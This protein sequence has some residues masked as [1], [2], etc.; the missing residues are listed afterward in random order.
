MDI[1]DD[2]GGG[3]GIIPGIEVTTNSSSSHD[4][5]LDLRDNDSSNVNE[6]DILVRQASLANTFSIEDLTGSGTTASN[7]ESFLVTQ[8]PGNTARVRTGGSVV[9]YTTMNL[10]N[11]NTPAP[12]T[13]LM[14]A[15]GGV[16][17][18]QPVSIAVLSQVELD[19]LVMEA[20]N[21]WAATGLSP[22]QIATL[23]SVKVEIADLPDAYLAEIAGGH[24]RIDQDAGG[25]GWF[26][27]TTPLDD[28]EFS[29]TTFG[30][31]RY[32]D[33]A[34]A[35]AGR[36]DLLTALMHELGHHLGLPDEYT[37]QSRDT[38]MHGYLTPGE[39][40]LPSYPGATKSPG[41][42]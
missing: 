24:I 13:P 42:H 15:S 17:A 20:I 9:N 8:N 5:F 28:V 18:V 30:S 27:D 6:A 29:D 33:P 12:L 16:E 10:N 35:P 25:Y 4:I 31:R 32:T 7:V 37:A 14:A 21:R 11:T 23:Q 19:I 26:V 38:V 36:M 22:Q 40:R 1:D 39:R 34:S 3:N 41:I 2:G